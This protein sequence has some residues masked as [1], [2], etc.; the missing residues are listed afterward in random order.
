MAGMRAA[1][2]AKDAHEHDHAKQ[3][4]A[5]EQRQGEAADVRA[6]M[7]ACEGGV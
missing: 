2:P 4:L 1:L 7:H 3:V 6:L 5:V